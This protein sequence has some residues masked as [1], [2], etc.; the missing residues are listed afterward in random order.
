MSFGGLIL[1]N[2]GRNEL[3]RAEMGTKFELT[4]V[5]LGEGRYNGTYTAISSLVNKVMEIPIT[6]I[7]RT[8]DE[9]LLN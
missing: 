2:A 6:R 1:T 7:S 4:H 3:I 9:V 5:V 8:D